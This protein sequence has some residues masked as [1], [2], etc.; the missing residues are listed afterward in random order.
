VPKVLV[1]LPDWLYNI[2]DKELRGRMGEADSE[3]IRNIIIT[4]LYEQGYFK[5]K[6]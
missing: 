6:E 2:I 3:I 5:K 4:S 1:T